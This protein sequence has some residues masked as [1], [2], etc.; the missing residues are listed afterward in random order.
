MY[1]VENRE[2]GVGNGEYG[3][4]GLYRPLELIAGDEVVWY[5]LGSVPAADRASDEIMPRASYMRQ[6][7]ELNHKH[8]ANH[9]DPHGEIQL[10]R[11]IAHIHISTS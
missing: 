10:C 2:W 7:G 1:G 6:D 9:P 11:P 3:V 8:N 4:A 5:A